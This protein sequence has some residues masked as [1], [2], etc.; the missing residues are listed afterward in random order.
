[1]WI[2]FALSFL[3]VWNRMLWRNLR[4][5]GLPVLLPWFDVWSKTLWLTSDFFE[6]CPDFFLE[7]S[8]S[9]VRY[10]WETRHCKPKQLQQLKLCLRSSLRFWGQLSWGREGCRSSSSSLVGFVYRL[11]CIVGEVCCQIFRVSHTAAFLF[12]I[13]SFVLQVHPT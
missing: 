7:I 13:F 4:A 10:D 8:Q 1:M 9:Q 3:S 2:V 11:C 6:S 5:V 12:L